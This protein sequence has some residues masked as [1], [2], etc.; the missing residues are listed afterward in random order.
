MNTLAH[1]VCVTEMAF[2]G[3]LEHLEHNVELNRAKLAAP[4]SQLTAADCD[5]SL[6]TQSAAGDGGGG[7]G[8]AAQAEDPSAAGWDLVIGSDLVYNDAGI[9]SLPLVLAGLLRRRGCACAP[10]PHLRPSALCPRDPCA[11][12]APEPP[13]PPLPP[14]ALRTHP[15][16]LRNGG[17]GAAPRPRHPACTAPRLTP[18]PRRAAQDFFAH[19]AAAGLE[20]TE[21]RAPRRAAPR[22]RE[23][24]HLALAHKSFS[25]TKASR[26]Q[27]LLAHKSFTWPHLGG[28]A[29]SVSPGCRLPRRRPRPSRHSSRCPP[30]SPP[31]SGFTLL[32]LLALLYSRFWLYSTLSSGFTLLSLFW[33]YSTLSRCTAGVW[34]R[35][36]LTA[37]A[38]RAPQEMRIAVFRIVE[39]AGAP[40]AR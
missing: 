14:Q 9:K 29:R 18:A 3:A 34:R 27:K 17:S 13:P 19:L 38:P 1:K 11:C 2:G 4:L 28:L 16:P 23:S 24:A 26:A 7:E 20:A 33:L 32:S 39:R 5:W 21:A 12:A 25:R 10:V 6:W 31:A 8:G 15:A 22:R 35:T 37:A 30:R 36:R 40:S